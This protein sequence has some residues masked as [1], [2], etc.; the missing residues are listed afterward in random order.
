VIL[1]SIKL[2]FQSIWAAKFRAILTLLGIVIGISSVILFLAIGEGLRRGV[3]AEVNSLGTNIVFVLPGQLESG[4]G[5][6]PNILSADILKSDDVDDIRALP[7][8]QTVAPMMLVGGVLRHDSTVVPNAFIFGS[9]EHFFAVYKNLAIGK[10]RFFTEDDNR[11]RNRV[12]VLGP[13]TAQT[14]FGDADPLGQTVSIAKTEL[15]VIGVTRAPTT[16]SQLGGPDFS[17]LSALPIE[18][19]G[20]LADGKKI[21]RIGL[22]IKPDVDVPTA[23]ESVRQ[24]LFTRHAPEDV[25]VIT[26]DELLGVLNKLLSLLTGAVA[27]IASISLVVAGVGIMNVMLVSVTERTKEIGLRKAVGAPTSAILWQF[28]TEAITLSV[29]GSLVAVVLTL[30]A[31]RV[32]PRF[33]PITPVITAQSVELAVGVGLA[34]GLVFG[35]APALRAARLDPIAALRSE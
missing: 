10:G 33:A 22:V 27:A 24:A 31:T 18:T 28:L 23:K 17:S 7:S 11:S 8:V 30:V 4:A 6:N 34:V 13:S 29:L 5:F 16:S 2:A 21:F 32:I 20:D 26:Q 35:S 14:L 1:E 3:N 12:I 15:E 9:D 25:S 19:A